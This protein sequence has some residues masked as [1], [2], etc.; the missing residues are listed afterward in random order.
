[1]LSR[2]TRGIEL[3]ACVFAGRALLGPG[4]PEWGSCIEDD[5]RLVFVRSAVGNR[6]RRSSASWV[7]RD[8]VQ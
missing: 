6:N 8:F 5:Y 7:S 2:G 3:C 4:I 1:M